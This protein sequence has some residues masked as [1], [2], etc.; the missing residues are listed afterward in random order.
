MPD[1]NLVIDV[2]GWSQTE[3]FLSV[4]HHEVSKVVIELYSSSA[5]LPAIELENL[6]PNAPTV[7][8]DALKPGTEYK[9]RAKARLTSGAWT[10]FSDL[11]VVTTLLG[12]TL[13]SLSKFSA[14]YPISARSR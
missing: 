5:Q 4:K 14:A 11:K 9:L 12:R 3:I 7:V 10:G 6:L 13:S 1:Q 8:V 2:A